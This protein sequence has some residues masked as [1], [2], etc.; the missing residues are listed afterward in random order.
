MEVGH[1]MIYTMTALFTGFMIFVFSDFQGTVALGALTG[2]TL[3]TGLFA[4]LFLLPA[5]ILSFEKGLNP[6]EEL[7]ESVLELP[8]EADEDPDEE[9]TPGLPSGPK[10]ES[11]R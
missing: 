11:G 9:T 7:E 1:S 6:K 5:L 4:N 10:D 3:A 8:D 2:L